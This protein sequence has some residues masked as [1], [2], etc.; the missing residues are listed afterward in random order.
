M[1]EECEKTATGEMTRRKAFIWISVACGA[2]AGAIVAL[3]PVGLLLA[4]LLRKRVEAWRA[5]GAVEQ[6]KVGET[7]AVSFVNADSNNWGGVTD[8]SGAWLRRVGDEEFIAFRLNCTHLGCPVRWEAAANLFM[9]P[10]HGG[11]YYSDGRVAGGPP[12]EP[13]HRYEVRV[14]EGQVEIQTAPIPIT[15]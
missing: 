13:L 9:C 2:V 12:P 7:V 10:C 1:S 15:T 3:P 11:V 14:R 5:V 8:K 4:P 6:Y